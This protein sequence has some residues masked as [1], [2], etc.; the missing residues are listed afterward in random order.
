[1]VITQERIEYEH[2]GERFVI[3]PFADAHIGNTYCDIKGIKE[4]LK[5]TDDHT[6]IIGLGDTLDS[7]IVTDRRYTKH[8]DSTMADAIIDDQIDIAYE[9]LAPYKD[10]ILGLGSG[11]HEEV[12]SRHYGDVAQPISSA[13]GVPYLGYMGFVNLRLNYS[14][15]RQHGY[16]MLLHHGHGMGRLLG[17]KMINLQRL[18]HKFDADIY[19]IGHI[20]T[21]MQHRDYVLGIRTSGRRLP[22][23]EKRTRYYASAPSYFDAYVADT[24]TNYAQ[25]KALYPQPNGCLRM[26]LTNEYVKIEPLLGD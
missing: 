11:N 23:L 12:I 5:D 3:K 2:Y 22:T 15:T 20:H 14:G 26:E 21:Y 4:Y 24:R 1:M 7:V 6:Y 17:A 18:S 8:A 16:T 9:L 10:R 19:L 13:L 25:T